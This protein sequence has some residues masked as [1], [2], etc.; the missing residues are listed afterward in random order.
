MCFG[1]PG[2]IINQ[3]VSYHYLSVPKAQLRTQ[4]ASLAAGPKLPEVTVTLKNLVMTISRRNFQ[5]CGAAGFVGLFYRGYQP[6]ALLE[7]VPPLIYRSTSAPKK[8][9]H[10]AGQ[11]GSNQ[12]ATPGIMLGS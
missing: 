3:G 8:Y 11:N 6:L 10:A 9:H 1:F 12:G 7:E 2:S 5:N 4:S